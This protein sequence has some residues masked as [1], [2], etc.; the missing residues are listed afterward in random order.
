[1]SK[2][3]ATYTP[4]QV[5]EETGRLN[6][7]SLSE[8]F[9]EAVIRSLAFRLVRGK[10][11]HHR[12]GFPVKTRGACFKASSRPVPQKTNRSLGGVRVKRWGKS[13][14]LIEQ[15]IGHGK[16]NPMQDEIGNRAARLWFRVRRTPGNWGFDHPVK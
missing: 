1:M 9:R 7:L 10:S 14:P 3:K 4:S 6:F 11:G 16:P 5:P 13:P 12:A 2:D 15:S 8:I